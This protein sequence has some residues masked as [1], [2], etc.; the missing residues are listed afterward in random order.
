[1]GAVGGM[2][3]HRPA[4]KGQTTNPRVH[5]VASRGH[6]TLEGCFFEGNR[7]TPPQNES[8]F[9]ISES[10][11][12]ALAQFARSPNARQLIRMAAPLRQPLS[13]ATIDDLTMKIEV[14]T[15][16]CVTEWLAARAHL[17]ATCVEMVESRR[18]RVRCMR[19]LHTVLRLPLQDL[20][21][22]SLLGAF[23]L[24]HSC[25]SLTRCLLSSRA[26]THVSLGFAE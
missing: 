9:P 4:Q 23:L 13:Q 17:Q 19:H 26:H 20:C 22:D 1:M 6:W 18:S 2:P 25:N 12:G 8:R 7:Y 10:P 16:R 3:N 21:P 14:R 5:V 11:L 24:N 15:S